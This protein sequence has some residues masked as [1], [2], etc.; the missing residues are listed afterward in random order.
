[1]KPISGNPIKDSKDSKKVE[2]TVGGIKENGE[3]NRKEASLKE[4]TDLWGFE[5]QYPAPK[6][7]RISRLPHRPIMH[8]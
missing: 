5:P 1:M 7:G 6:A 4:K 2:I 8:S 3:T